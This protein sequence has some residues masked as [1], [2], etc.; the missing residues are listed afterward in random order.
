MGKNIPKEK[1]HMKY[2]KLICIMLA[3][4]LVLTGCGILYVDHDTDKD[5]A[6]T[7]V[8]E[9]T[10]V[11]LPDVGAYEADYEDEVRTFIKDLSRTTYDGDAFKIA[12]AS[13]KY[14]MEAD[15]KTPTVIAEDFADRNGA[16]EELLD[17]ELVYKK[18]NAGTMRDELRAAILAEDYYADLIMI[19]EDRIGSFAV[20]NLI[21]NLRSL[22]GLR[23]NADY[24]YKTSVSATC[25]GNTVYG[26]AGPASVRGEDLSCIFFNKTLIEKAGLENPETLVENGTWTADKYA[27]YCTKIASLDGEYYSAAAQNT[28]TYLADLFYFGMGGSLVN[29]SIGYSPALLLKIENYKKLVDRT[30]MCVN[31]DG[32]YGNALNGIDTFISGNTLF[33]VE[34]VSAMEKLANT[35]FDWGILPM[36]KNDA[37]QKQYSSLAY[38]ADTLFFCGVE[39]T[40]DYDKCADV[41]AAL[42]IVSYGYSRDAFIKNASYYY[43]RDNASQIML[44]KVMENPVYDFAYTFYTTDDSIGNATFS[45]V[46]NAVQGVNSVDNYMAYHSDSFY[47]AMYRLFDIN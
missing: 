17:I 38:C 37:E 33:L 43:L 31:A 21:I 30:A 46:R 12:V 8:A 5:E 20:D 32:A 35:S 2:L 4:S 9:E 24:F 10:T 23:L 45:A 15:E 11:T 47:Y 39:T 1:N 6:E 13:D 27:E 28:A 7:T 14:T 34:R 42:N 29:S 44:S 40:S 36:P 22:P 19:P 41:L 3:F 16:C 18:T 26:I 25:G